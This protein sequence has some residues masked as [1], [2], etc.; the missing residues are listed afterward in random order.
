LS[1]DGVAAFFFCAVEVAVGRFYHGVR[2]YKGIGCICVDS[3][4]PEADGDT[5]DAFGSL[6]AFAGDGFSEPLRRQVGPLKWCF[7]VHNQEL[8]PAVPVHP[9]NALANGIHE[10][11]C[12]GIEQL[13]SGL[14]QIGG[15]HF[16]EAIAIA[17]QHRKVMP[18]SPG[19]LDLF[20]QLLLWILQH[21][22]AR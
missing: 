1:S 8:F 4:H 2:G 18:V 13:I 11:L 10:N 6:D 3:R 9:V 12:E 15:V 17:E 19:P 14:V 20:R 5:Q 16:L 21:R 7:R 22:Q